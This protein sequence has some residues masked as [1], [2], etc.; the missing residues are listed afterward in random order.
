MTVRR[1]SP[2]KAE[3]LQLQKLYRTDEKIGERLGGVPAYLVAYWRRKKNIPKYSLPKFSEQEIRNLWERF[4]DDEKAG[5]ELGISKAAFYN[6]RRRY[7]LREKPAF[8]K[9]EQLELNF[10]GTRLGFY[11]SNL[12]GKRSMAQKILARSADR[13]EVSIGETVQ[14]T[15]DVITI[16]RGLAAVIEAFGDRKADMVKNPNRIVA[17]AGDHPGM[18][19]KGSSLSRKTIGEFV[20]RQGVRSFYDLRDG[21]CQQVVIERGNILP[22][23]AVVGFG[24]HTMTYGCLGALSIGIDLEEMS[25][26]WANGTCAIEVP[27]TVRIMVTGRRY[28]GIY[29][30]DIVLSILNR[31]GVNGARGKAVEYAGS[32]LS[33]MSISE[34]FTVSNLS[35]ELGAVTAMCP[36]D[37]TTR[38]YLTGRV[39]TRS[40]PVIPDK[41]AEYSEIYQINID[42]LVPQIFRPGAEAVIK[43]VADMEGAPVHQV[44]LGGCASGRFDELR[45]A[46]DVLKGKQVHPECRMYVIPGSR[47]TYLEAL[48]KGLIRVFVEAGA[49]VMSSSS[50]PCQGGTHDPLAEGERCLATTNSHLLGH[51]GSEK[52]ELLLCSSAT[53]AVS[54]LNGEITEPTRFVK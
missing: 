41:D 27:D 44:I 18:T 1:K 11:A 26:L 35:T 30:K 12:Y 14:V 24:P 8:L 39:D 2:T 50:C 22:G 32:V 38:R 16:D 51:I 19:G 34:R 7:G 13:E 43:P 15:P 45:V 6:W 33:Q 47:A 53:A 46:A 3:L 36:Y 52:S 21:I 20:K 37:A 54:A 48:K 42:Q 29:A 25:T 5:L 49:M 17:I 9:L 23:L 10:P 40:S 31:L 28:R 4:G